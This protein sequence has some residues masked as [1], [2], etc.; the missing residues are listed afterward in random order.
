[1]NLKPYP[2]YFESGTPWISNY[3]SDWEMLKTKYLFKE[4]VEKGYQDEPL[5]AATQTLGVVPKTLYGTRTVIAQKDLHLLKLVEPGDFVISLRSFQ[6]G[7]E[8]AYYRGIISPAYT[9][10]IPS[11]KIDGG[12]FKHLAKSKPFIKLLTTCVTGIREGQNIDYEIL[13][14]TKLPVPS[15]LDQKHI[16]RYLDWKTTQIAKFIKAKRRLIELLKEQKQVIIN[17]AVTGNI[18]IRTGNPYPKYKDSGVG[19]LSRVPDGW[20]VRKIKYL[21]ASSHNSFV[22]GPFG[23]SLKSVHYVL[24]GDVYVI[25]SGFITKGYFKI[26]EFK[27]ITREH[28]ETIKRSECQ[29]DDIIIAKIGAYYGMSGILPKLEKKS[30]VS[31]N[32]LKLTV[33]RKIC[34]NNFIHFALLVAKNKDAFKSIVGE[35]AQPALSLGGMN[36]ISLP[37]PSLNEQEELVKYLKNVTSA[38]D[39]TIKQIEF[40]VDLFKEYRTRIVADVVTG[41]IDVRDIKIPEFEEEEALT[42]LEEITDVEDVLDESTVDNDL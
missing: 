12:Y 7:I 18:D 42:D 10:L 36:G 32:S 16:A 3:P 27:T 5:L 26:K 31:G 41:K 34:D 38:L 1:M 30:V 2:K 13:R 11:N 23:S 17:D 20:E 14:R 22:D 35:T 33:N 39:I 25:E 40:E 9:I 19:W 28:F 37:L 8:K 24:N 6:G 29:E 21:K 15:L 4:R